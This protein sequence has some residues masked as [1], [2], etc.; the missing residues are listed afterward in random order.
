[1][2]AFIVCVVNA[3]YRFRYSNDADAEAKARQF[4][5]SWYS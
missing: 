4:L 3:W 5:G 1:M 2:K